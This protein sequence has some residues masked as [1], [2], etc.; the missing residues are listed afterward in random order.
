MHINII[1]EANRHSDLL[2]AAEHA[3]TDAI[4]DGIVAEVSRIEDR[5]STAKPR[6]ADERRAILETAERAMTALQIEPYSS[7]IRATF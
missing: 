4:R 3:V 7:M 5:L 2:K 1:K 6:T